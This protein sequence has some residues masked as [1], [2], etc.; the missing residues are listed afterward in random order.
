MLFE[1]IFQF[2]TFFTEGHSSVFHGWR[3]KFGTTKWRTADISKIRN[4]EYWNNESRVIRFFYFRIYFLFLWLFK[5][6]EHSKYIFN[7]V[8][9]NSNFL[10]FLQVEF[11]IGNWKFGIGKLRNFKIFSIC[12]IKVWLQKLAI[13]KLFVQ[14]IFR[15][16]RNF[17]NSHISTFISYSRQNFLDWQVREIIK[18]LKLSNFEN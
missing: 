13:L 15:T 7:N 4:F 11:G 1:N 3:S 17:P 10:E 2:F 12:K 14:S 6:F 5:L 9:S 8:P 18:F 16:T